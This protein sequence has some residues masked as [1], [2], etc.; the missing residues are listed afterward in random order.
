MTQLFSN[1]AYS[2]L[3]ANA[4]NVTTTLTLATGT[5]ARFPLPTGGD[6]FLLTLVGLDTNTNESSWEIVKVTAR[7][8]DTLTVV[9]AQEGTSAVAWNSGTRVE[10]RATAGTFSGL[11]PSANPLFTGAI[12]GD[13]SNATASS[14]V[15]FQ[16]TSANSA[17]ILAT[18][19]SGTGTASYLQ[20]FNASDAD[21]AGYV[22]LGITN[23]IA[24]INSAK[25]GTGTALPLTLSVNSSEKM[26]IDTTGSIGM[27][28][29]PPTTTGAPSLFVYPDSV[30]GSA[31]GS[32]FLASNTYY[33]TAFKAV[34]TNTAGSYQISGDTHIFSNA[35]SVAANAAQTFVER[36]RIGPNGQIGIGGANYGTA[37]QVLTSGG[38]G[39]APTWATASGGGGGT[40]TISNK[41]GAYT[42]V[43]GD[44][45]TIINCTA[46]TFTVSLTAAASLG[47]GFTCTIWNTA[48]SASAIITIDPAGAETIDGLS[49]L[50][51]YQGEGLD[52]VCN[53]TN[54]ETS[55][56]K[57]MRGYAENYSSSSVRP[58]A[59]GNPSIAIGQRSVAAGGASIAMCGGTTNGTSAIAIGGF[60]ASDTATAGSNYSTAIGMTSGHLCSITATGAGAM[61]LGGSYASGTDS[62]AAAIANN[63]SS[64]GAQNL[65]DVAIGQ[66]AKANGGYSLAAGRFT[67]SSGN[68]AISIGTL[69]TASGVGAVA[70]GGRDLYGAQATGV[71]SCAIGDGAKSSQIGKYA[72][73]AYSS[74]GGGDSQYGLIVLNAV[75]TTTTAVVLT[76]DAA[77]AS[78]TN[79]LIL[80]SGQAMAISGTL[81]AKQTASGN[82]AGWT[83]TG[84]VSNNA[85]TMAVSGLALTA[86]GTD[87]IVLGAAP[88]IAVDNTNKGVTITSG[89]KAATSIRWVANVQTSEVKYA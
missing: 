31:G 17:T 34:T 22:Y 16:T 26:R 49:T 60:G 32:L 47:S 40:K 76:S 73:A 81:I 43:S 39:A 53:G 15:A 25:T 82:M 14:R 68:F 44:L 59:S 77:A 55:Y 28:V 8:T 51:L 80:A 1:N 63:T 11:T 71:G 36:L 69:S 50:T 83:I 89:Y 88:T 5:G 41:T 3:A 64:Y 58:V 67:T 87:S 12:N 24:T 62:F 75:T 78:T 19:P 65:D 10:S 4:S 56:K 48:T 9:R 21:N 29:V 6:Y 13:F 66:S 57:T 37:G 27:N 86:I 46:N 18:K 79:Q 33:N 20:S 23:T 38:A 2:S 72:F 61:A 74:S 45:G 85:G 42:V 52:I 7:A 70:I 84:I 30:I 35:V 54:W